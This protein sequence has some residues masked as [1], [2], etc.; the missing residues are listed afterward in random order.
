VACQSDGELTFLRLPAVS[1][2][3]TGE[4][5]AASSGVGDLDGDDC[6]VGTHPCPSGASESAR[7]GAIW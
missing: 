1:L 6:R 5:I 3:S 2:G 4:L 7:A